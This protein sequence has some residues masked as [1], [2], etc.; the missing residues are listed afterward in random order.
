[1]A[2]EYCSASYSINPTTLRATL[3]I[4]YD[5]PNALPRHWYAIP[6]D[7]LDAILLQLSREGWEQQGSDSYQLEAVMHETRYY[8]RQRRA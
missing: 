2:W 8:R 6:L 7:E 4:S 3:T 5:A 1:M